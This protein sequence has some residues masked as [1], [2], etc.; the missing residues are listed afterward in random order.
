MQEKNPGFATATEA[1]L[2]LA[3]ALDRGDWSACIMCLTSQCEYEFRGTVSKGA[4]DIISS[5][6]VIGEWVE[7]TF[8]SVR[9]ESAVE[10]LGAKVAKIS[11]RDLMEHQGHRLDF[12][13]QQVI[14][15]GDDGL[16][17]KIRHIDI[18]GMPE[19]VAEFNKACGVTKPSS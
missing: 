12:R 1:A 2:T 17:G 13:C 14:T 7:A 3:S 5:Y 4:E 6:R 9:Y 18:D 15:L 8:E 11:F 16:I 10:T 19:K